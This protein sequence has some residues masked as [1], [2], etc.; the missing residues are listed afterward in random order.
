MMLRRWKKRNWGLIVYAKGIPKGTS[1]Q[2]KAKRV[3]V[4]SIQAYNKVYI[5]LTYPSVE[6]ITLQEAS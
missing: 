1:K 2:P 6:E 4:H 3:P 5:L